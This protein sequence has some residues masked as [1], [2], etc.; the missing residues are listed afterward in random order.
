MQRG[1][2]VVLS[3]PSPTL[4]QKESS[5][6]YISLVEVY[7]LRET[8]DQ[9]PL[10]D[11]DDYE[12][13]ADRIWQMDRATIE[14]QVKILGNLQHADPI[15]LK[16]AGDEST[17]RLRYAVRYVNE[18]G[19]KSSFSNSVAIEL[20]A[21]VAAPPARLLVVASIQDEVKVEWAAPDSNID[22]TR[23]AS[24]VGYNV[25]R[26]TA[27]RE[28]FI[29]PLNSEPVT[30]SHFTD[31]KF[32]YKA[33]YVYVVRALSQGATGLIESAD[34]EPAAL[35]P[36]DTFAPA[37]PEPVSLA[38]ANG[39]ISL[40]WPTSQEADVVGYNIYRAESTESGNVEWIKLTAQPLSNVTAFRDDRVVIG[41][42]YSYRVTAVDR[43]GN[44]SA[45]SRVVS[46]TANP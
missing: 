46:E 40:F 14:A 4:V 35:T 25:Y 34:S 9:E 1:S 2:T 32:Q 29:K 45:P 21:A 8:K 12:A 16:G 30:E 43:F 5:R 7:R 26:R 22:G 44:E 36:V 28:A 33:D 6:D 3:W 20:L 37:A 31:T 17:L 41:K 18:R 23:P 24:V 27:K 39:L 19:Q 10:L 42:R 11:P 13:A 38:S 15:N